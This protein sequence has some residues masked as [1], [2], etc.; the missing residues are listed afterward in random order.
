MDWV[1]APYSADHFLARRR[2]IF[3]K[4]GLAP[5]DHQQILHFEDSS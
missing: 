1:N 5:I 4:L 2:P 3:A